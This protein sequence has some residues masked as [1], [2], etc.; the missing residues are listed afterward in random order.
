MLGYTSEDIDRITDAIHDA[1]LFYL[2]N[3]G[4][5]ENMKDNLEEANSLLFGLVV[6]G[7][8]E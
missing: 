1:K 7:H 8:I 4:Q 5:D 6:E 2:N 3:N